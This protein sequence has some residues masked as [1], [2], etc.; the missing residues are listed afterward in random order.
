MIA[1]EIQDACRLGYGGLLEVVND[2]GSVK[3]QYPPLEEEGWHT[4]ALSSHTQL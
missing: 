2:S 1:E 3:Y 4:R